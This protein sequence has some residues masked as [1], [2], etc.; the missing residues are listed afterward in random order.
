MRAALS[1]MA[2][3]MAALSIGGV[4]AE[5]PPENLVRNGDFKNGLESWRGGKGISAEAVNGVGTLTVSMP[6]VGSDQKIALDSNWFKLKL[7]MRMRATGVEVGDQDWKDARL[8]MAFLGA[9]GKR[10][11]DWPNVFHAS[12]T[13]DWIVCERIYLIPEGA[14]SLSLSPANYGKSGKA[15]FQDIRLELLEMRPLKG[16]VPPPESISSLW[17]ADKAWRESSAPARGYASTVSGVCCL[18]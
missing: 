17:G 16:D 3:G 10:V 5:P 2:A 1:W 6:G 13:T 7:T 18:S 12:G 14:A 11:G 15:E 4:L 8:A 9:D